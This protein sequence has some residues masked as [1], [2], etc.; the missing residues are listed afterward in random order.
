MKVQ[1]NKMDLEEKE[2]LDYFESNPIK[3]S[4]ESSKEEKNNAMLASA[5]FLKKTER[6]NIRM[7][8]FDLNHIKRKA[9]QQGVPYQTLVSSVLHKYA[10]GSSSF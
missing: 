8:K 9:A 2:I 3:E 10:S 4:S 6:I 1:N 7:N 5:N